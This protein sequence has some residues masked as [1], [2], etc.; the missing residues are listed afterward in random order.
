[1]KQFTDYN[2]TPLKFHKFFH[3]IWTPLFFV[4]SFIIMLGDIAEYSSFNHITAVNVTYAILNCILIGC[5]FVGFF[6]WKLYSWY[7]VCMPR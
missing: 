2:S 5:Y 6:R 7:C 4:S 3:Y 1:M